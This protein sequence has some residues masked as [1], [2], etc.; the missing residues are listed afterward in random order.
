M[1]RIISLLLAIV[2]LISCSTLFFSCEKNTDEKKEASNEIKTYEEDSIFYER[3]LVEDGLGEA[4]YGGRALRI[5]AYTPTEIEILEEERNKGDLIKDSRFAR[6]EA[7]ANRF[8]VKFD[9]VYTGTYSEQNDYVSKSVLSGNDEFDLFM[10]MVMS[11][12]GMVTKKI[13]L[14]WYD[15]EHI[16]FSKPWWYESNSTDLTY[17]GKNLIAI[18]HLNQT[19]VGGA[20]C[21]YYNK[22][23]ASSYELGDLYKLVLDG[24]W[25][26]DKLAEM[27]KDIYVD[28]GNDIRD[29]GDF[30]GFGLDQGTCLNSF[31]WAF[32]NPVCTKDADGVPQITVKTDKIDAIINDV[33]D[34]C[35]NNSGVFFEPDKKDLGS[36]A[37]DQFY[38]K[39]AIFKMGTVYGATNENMRNFE[40]E[41]GM[42]P[43]P[44]YTEEQP[45]Y[46]TMV[47]GH[48]TAL[49]IPKTCKDTEFVGRIVEALSA[50]S[51]KTVTP[52]L[53]EIA[54][55]TR[56]LRDS[57]SKEI[58]DMIIDGTQFDFGTVYDN[59]QGFA[60]MLQR[61]M[62]E[63]NNNFQSYYTV[64]FPKARYQIRTTVKAIDRM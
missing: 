62:A 59:W 39:K 18:S 29:T 11:M 21:L 35:F 50:E 24:K 48:H 58:M 52:T 47:G 9:V 10:G 41:Y 19:A 8:N 1:K 57:E 40:D 49:A 6:N 34:F 44:K 56:Y 42:L 51:W 61:M 55:K 14:N 45:E 30:Y 25:T 64:R 36:V 37:G 43:L 5:V 23:L 7:V 4:D 54:L 31:L 15:V 17:N 27:I 3:S 38:V 16:D 33:Y 13:F 63:G 12:G 46:K 60:F 20:Y 32:D 28:D 2:M 22:N 53:Y 26:F